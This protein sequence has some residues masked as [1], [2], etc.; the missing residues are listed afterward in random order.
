MKN[1]FSTPRLLVRE[2]QTS[3]LLKFHEL[4]GNKNV[5]QYASI[6]GKGM[7]EAES[8]ADLL[9]VIEKYT[10]PNNVLWVWAIIRK[11]NQDFVGTC[12]LVHEGNAIYEIGYRLLE[13][14]WGNGFGKEVTNGLVDFAIDNWNSKRLIAVVDKRNI[15]SI[16]ILEQSKLSLIR[17][18]WNTETE[19]QDLEFR[20]EV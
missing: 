11:S 16:K 4:Q 7:N 6:S 14:E 19:T 15:G 17:E 10:L 8:E 18:F 12:A 5:M 2:L 13:S 3:D 20:L 9:S 1:I